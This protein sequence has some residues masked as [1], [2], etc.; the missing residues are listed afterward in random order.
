MATTIFI[1]IEDYNH[2]QPIVGAQEIRL[3]VI[4]VYSRGANQNYDLERPW[5]TV[6]TTFRLCYL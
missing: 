1:F 6:G 2:A 5:H 3:S 4:Q